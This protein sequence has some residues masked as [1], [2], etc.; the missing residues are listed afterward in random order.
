MKKKDIKN[1][2]NKKTQKSHE[3]SA[4]L[5]LSVHLKEKFRK[6]NEYSAQLV[7]A[8][9]VKEKLRKYQALHCTETRERVARASTWC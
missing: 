9:H 5:V 3:Y 6:S 7:V 4:Q 2:Q 1:K 8:V